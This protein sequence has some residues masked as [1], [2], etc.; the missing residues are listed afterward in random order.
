MATRFSPLVLPIQLHDFPQQYNQRIKLYD[1]EGNVSS[2]KHLYY[3]NDFV[4]LE[5]VDY[6]DVKMRLFAQR[7]AGEERKWFRSLPATSIL[8]FEF[9]ETNFLAK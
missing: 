5:E 4:D 6:E 3:F 9:F 7:L 1:V 8:N 2:Q